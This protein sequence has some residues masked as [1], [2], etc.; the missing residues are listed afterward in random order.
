MIDIIPN[1]HPFFVHFSVG[2][3]LISAVFYF[4]SRVMPL[5]C[6]VQQQWFVTA[7]WLLWAGSLLTIATV[8]AGWFAFNAVEHDSASHLAMSLHR[9]WAI[10]TAILFIVLAIYSRL[11]AHK[12]RKPSGLFLLLTL[13]ASGMLLTTAYLGA[14]VVY[15]HGIGVISLPEVEVGTDYHHDHS[16]ED[17]SA[18]EHD[19]QH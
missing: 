4:G 14:E 8:I 13:I 7:N 11:R 1:W 12:W 16:P 5:H 19:H 10:P 9:N 18:D 6:S 3:L 17:N 15:R 2:L